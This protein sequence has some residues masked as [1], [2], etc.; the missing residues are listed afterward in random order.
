[1]TSAGATCDEGGAKNAETFAAFS[2]EDRTLAHVE[3]AIETKLR[4]GEPFMFTWNIDTAEG[5]GRTSVWVIRWVFG[6]EWDFLDT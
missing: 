5:S 3:A 6:S 1:M 2:A 4:R